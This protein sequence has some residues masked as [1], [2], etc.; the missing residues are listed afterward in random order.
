MNE[1]QEKIVEQETPQ[2][3]VLVDIEET[4]E[5]K[6]DAPKVEAKKKS[7]QMFVLS[8]QKKN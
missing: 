5:K 1:A 4:E 8:N 2:E 7:E 3:N 6:E